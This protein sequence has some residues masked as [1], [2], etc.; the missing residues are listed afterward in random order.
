MVAIHCAGDR[1]PGLLDREY[2]L[3]LVAF[4]DLSSCRVEQDRLNTKEGQGG[5]SRLGLGRSG[6]RCDDD[7]A[8]FGLPV[9]INDGALLL[10]DMLPVPLPGLGVDGFSD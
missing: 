1:R 4:D 6:Q 3:L 7:G 5:S 2:T 9:C 8:S 10:S